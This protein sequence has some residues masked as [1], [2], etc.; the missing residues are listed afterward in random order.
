[1]GRLRNFVRRL[2]KKDNAAVLIEQADGTVAKFRESDLAPAYINLM[3]RHR[4]G[5]NSP[6]LPPEHPLITAVKNSPDPKWQRS[7]YTEE[8]GDEPPE[9]LSEQ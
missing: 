4:V 7:L 8:I 3:D 9:D 2:E 1:M 5:L 6:D